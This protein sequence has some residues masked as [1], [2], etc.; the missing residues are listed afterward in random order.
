MKYLE[1]GDSVKGKFEWIYN[2]SLRFD[3]GIK[4]NL[5]SMTE[6]EKLVQKSFGNSIV[7]LEDIHGDTINFRTTY[8]GNLHIT[9]NQGKLI[10]LK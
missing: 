5:D 9:L 3:S 6:F 10:R 4:V 7:K 1:N 2:C 8:S